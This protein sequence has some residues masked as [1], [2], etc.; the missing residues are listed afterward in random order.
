MPCR[1]I[2]VEVEVLQIWTR[3]DQSILQR[4][5]IKSEVFADVRLLLQYVP[6][7]AQKAVKIGGRLCRIGRQ[8]NQKTIRVF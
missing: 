1:Q 3:I 7:H 4:D 5:K 2:V 6:R 8:N